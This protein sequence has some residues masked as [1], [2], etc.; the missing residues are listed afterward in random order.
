MSNV[1]KLEQSMTHINELTEPLDENALVLHEIPVTQMIDRFVM[2]VCGVFNWIW[3]ILVIVIIVNV[4]LR[5]V[6]SQGMIE[7]EELQWH[8]FAI[9]W[10][11]GLSSTF[12]LDGHVRVDVI[13]DKLKYKTKVWLELL[14]LL[15]LLFPF[16]GFITYYSIPFVE[17]SWST[18][19]TSTSANGLSARWVVKGFLLFSFALLNLA[20]A[21]RLIK[22][23]VSLINGSP[24]N[25]NNNSVLN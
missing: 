12:I 13:H 21:S 6:F 11:V 7:L 15:A 19:E 20:A 5:Y 2:T 1:N 17:L 8:L 9:G 16:I 14:G 22:V 24:I 4:V 3:V 25:N 18:S 23:I 10:L